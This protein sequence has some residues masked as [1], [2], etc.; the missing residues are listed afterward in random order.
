M[1]KQLWLT[2]FTT[3]ITGVFTS[4]YILTGLKI[5]PEDLIMGITGKFIETSNNNQII[6]SWT[7]IIEAYAIIGVLGLIANI[8][9]FIKMRLPGI[10]VASS[11]FFGVLTLFLGQPI[12][13]V[14]FL[15]I[16]AIVCYFL[17][18]SAPNFIS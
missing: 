7:K 17:E 9:S 14:I 12:V 5:Q 11:G 18:G 2:Y 15:F 4:I 3:I 10:I 1:S 16:G 8:I 6:S 13:G